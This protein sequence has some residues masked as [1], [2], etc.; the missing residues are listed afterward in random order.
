MIKKIMSAC[1]LSLLATHLSFAAEMESDAQI[2][3]TV[4]SKISAEPSLKGTSIKIATANGVVNLS[5]KVDS[6]TQANTATELAQSTAGVNDVD[7]G[8]LTVKGSHHPLDDSLITSKVKGM[9]IQQKLFGDK[10]IAAITIKVE[11]N[12]GVVSLSGTADNQE[13][14][15]NAIKIAKSIKGVKSVK[16]TV[17]IST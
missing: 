13:Q 15:D 7:T 6:S 4:Q 2:N 8:H 12:N 1:I 11:T 17:K 5:G 3:S 14:I 16:S 9:F 10:E